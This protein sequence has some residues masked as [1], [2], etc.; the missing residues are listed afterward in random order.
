M[1]V[2]VL[3]AGRLSGA[4]VRQACA[5]YAERVNRFVRLTVREVRPGPAHAS[6][7]V[8]MRIEGERL[9]SAVPRGAHTVAL[10]RQG[11][12]ETTDSFTRKLA[13]WRTQAVDV[14]FLIGGALGLSR[15]V[16]E[17]CDE[18]MSLSPLTFPHD[19]ARLVLLEQLYR[20]GTILQ[21]TPYHK[22][23]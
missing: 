4:G 12:P 14:A 11:R 20:A 13:D 16:L 5:D 10:S 3:D 8:R 9:L 15:D 21:G 22:G 2:H 18:R 23:R 19:I 6:P 17:R 7:E 1:V